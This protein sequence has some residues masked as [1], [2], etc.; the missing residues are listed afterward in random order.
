MQFIKILIIQFITDSK[1]K[2]SKIR[3][4]RFDS[5]Y[6]Y[7]QLTA[8]KFAHLCLISSNINKY[9]KKVQSL[10]KTSRNKKK[11]K[12]DPYSRVCVRCELIRLFSWRQNYT[13][14]FARSLRLLKTQSPV[15]WSKWV[16]FELCARD[17]KQ[18]RLRAVELIA[19]VLK[20]FVKNLHA[21]KH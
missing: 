13:N 11:V 10:I 18:K 15:G 20:S 4:K 14:S 7:P 6:Y 19:N 21:K 16:V 9:R 5:K 2:S 17:Y 12:R 1:Q 8:L 3:I